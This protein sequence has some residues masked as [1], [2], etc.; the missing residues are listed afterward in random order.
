MK[1]F[2]Y[3]VSC[4]YGKSAETAFISCLQ[5]FLYAYFYSTDLF[6]ALLVAKKAAWPQQLGRMS[7]GTCM[8]FNPPAPVHWEYWLLSW[9]QLGLAL[10]HGGKLMCSQQGQT[11]LI[12]NTLQQGLR[13]KIFKKRERGREWDRPAPNTRYTLQMTD[14]SKK[15]SHQSTKHVVI[16]QHIIRYK[17][18]T[19]QSLSLLYALQSPQLL[20]SIK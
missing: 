18:S 3:K 6:R 14:K 20:N 19:H 4:L 16:A 10:S 5:A 13:E 17:S 8:S 7:Q 2:W 9:T 11:F 12:L 15:C 1:T